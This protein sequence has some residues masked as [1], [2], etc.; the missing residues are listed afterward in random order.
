MVT[1]DDTWTGRGEIFF[2]RDDFKGN[3][4]GQAHRVFKRTRGEILNDSVELEG[5]QKEGGKYSKG[6]ADD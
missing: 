4:R 5:P 1:D 6:G 3:A 2:A